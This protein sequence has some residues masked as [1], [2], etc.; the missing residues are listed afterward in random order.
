MNLPVRSPEDPVADDGLLA[1]GRG[2]IRSPVRPR[3][4]HGEDM[5]TDAALHLGPAA[6]N[7]G[8]VQIILGLAAFTLDQHSRQRHLRIF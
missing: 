7:L 8:F 4:P 1:A 3:L 5:S 6:A 2:S